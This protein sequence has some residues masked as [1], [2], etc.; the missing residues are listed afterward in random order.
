MGIWV[1]SIAPAHDGNPHFSL[2][3]L[4]TSLKSSPLGTFRKSFFSLFV[5]ALQTS[6][7]QR[8]TKD[9][10]TSTELAI[11]LYSA[12]QTYVIEGYCCALPRRDGFTHWSILSNNFDLS[13]SDNVLIRKLN[14]K[15]GSCHTTL[16]L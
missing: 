11:V 9:V 16:F 6:L 7:M 4:M 1:P 15:R 8:Q 10:E 14:W 3:S 12:V 5:I 13:L 2:Y